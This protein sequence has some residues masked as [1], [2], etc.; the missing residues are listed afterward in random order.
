MDTLLFTVLVFAGSTAAGFFGALTGL[1]GG[2]IM[3]PLMVRLFRCTQIQ[4]HATALMG[5]VFTGLAG[6][7]WPVSFVLSF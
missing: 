3:I 5:L 7:C 4:A 1:G 2:V 6:A